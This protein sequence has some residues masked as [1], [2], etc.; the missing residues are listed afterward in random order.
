MLVAFDSE[1]LSHLSKLLL[2][3]SNNILNVQPLAHCIPK[4]RSEGV[5]HP[6]CLVAL[7]DGLVRPLLQRRGPLLSLKLEISLYLQLC[8][9]LTGPLTT[10]GV[11]L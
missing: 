11:L 1:D 6:T 4:I 7:P 5:G 9:E 2:Q 3:P 10:R 8:L